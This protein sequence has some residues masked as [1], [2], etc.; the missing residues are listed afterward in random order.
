M[1]RDLAVRSCFVSV[2]IVTVGTEPGG[3]PKHKFVFP[4]AAQLLREVVEPGH[5]VDTVLS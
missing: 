1:P 5:T 2:M 4:P 3:G